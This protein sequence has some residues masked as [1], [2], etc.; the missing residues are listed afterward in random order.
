MLSSID[1]IHLVTTVSGGGCYPSPFVANNHCIISQGITST[2]R[3]SRSIPVQQFIV[4]RDSLAPDGSN[5]SAFFCP[6]NSHWLVSLVNFT[7][8]KP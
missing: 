5:Q 6:A 2:L 8:T 4:H 1:P 7:F 3:F